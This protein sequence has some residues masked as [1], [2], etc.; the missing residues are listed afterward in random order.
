MNRFWK[1]SF[2][3]V[4]TCSMLGGC[5]SS[6]ASDIAPVIDVL[7]FASAYDPCESVVVSDHGQNLQLDT[8]AVHRQ[9]LF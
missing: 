2:V 1:A 4:A 9:C 3:V 6:A 5:V 7:Q 8:L